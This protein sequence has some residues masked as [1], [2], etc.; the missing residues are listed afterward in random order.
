M[1]E[2]PSDVTPCVDAVIPV[3]GERPE[4]LDATLSA[5]LQQTIPFHR[6]IVVDDGSPEPV[7]L[8][9]AAPA[10]GNVMLLRL[11]Q[12]G[13][14]SIARNFG[15]AHSTAPFL[16]CVNTEVLPEQD[17][18]AVCLDGLLKLPSAGGCFTRLVSAT[19][20][21]LLTRWRMRFLEERFA[22]KSGAARFAPGHAVLFRREALNA[23]GGYDPK[24]R[25]HYEDSDI[26]FRMRAKHWETLYIAQSR[27]VSIQA[28][29]LRQLT[30]KILREMGWQPPHQGPLHRLYYN[31]SR[32]TLVRMG[33]NLVKGRLSF[34]P[35]DVAIWAYG[36]WAATSQTLRFRSSAK[37]RAPDHSAD[38]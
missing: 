7:T 38:P 35:I 16:A 12:N 31:H 25:L 9:E 8:P 2:P 14:I 5:C 23:V 27:C 3:Y 11:E 13:G 34:L 10:S 36:L 28:D 15:I 18:L 22:D 26:C 1:N 37:S 20:R 33:R 30:G 21:R 32:W 17:W 6:I 24:Y 4:A 19:P 29:S